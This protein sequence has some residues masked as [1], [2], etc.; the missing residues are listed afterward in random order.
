MSTELI[1]DDDVS[2][3]RGLATVAGSMAVGRAQQEVQ[4]AVI[5]AKRFP[6]SEAE[7]AKKIMQSC[8]RPRLAES[9][10]YEYSRGGQKISGP[11]IRLAEEMA[12]QWGNIKYD[13]VEL[14]R[15][16]G[17]SLCESYAWDMQTNTRVS[18]TF[19]V[20][21]VRDKKEGGTK[22]TSDRDIYEHIAN[23]GARRLRAC[24][25]AVIP[26]DIQEDALEMCDKTLIKAAKGEPLAERRKRMLAAFQEQFG[27][28]EAMIEAKL[29]HSVAALTENEYIRLRRIYTAIKDGF[30]GVADHFETGEQQASGRVRKSDI[31]VGG[32]KPA[33][34]PAPPE[35]H[36]YPESVPEQP[37]GPTEYQPNPDED[38]ADFIRRIEAATT[39]SEVAEIWNQAAKLADIL[40]ESRTAEI[41]AARKQRVVELQKGR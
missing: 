30:A 36:G 38:M 41:Q 39:G 18:K 31:S 24:I 23:Y 6:R 14:E 19:T 4:A 13:V 3:S 27:V 35:N 40:G 26:V 16:D 9:A 28:T 20:R 17:E 7:S 5:L 29:G 34:K 8:E 32:E 33:K 2:Q 37:L 12:R 10:T 11:S 15:R 25:L 22:L 1:V 21:H